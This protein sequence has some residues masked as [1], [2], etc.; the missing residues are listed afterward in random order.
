MNFNDH[1]LVLWQ[2]HPCFV[3]IFFYT[4]ILGKGFNS[5]FLLILSFHSSPI[6][7]LTRQ[8]FTTT[9]LVP[10]STPASILLPYG[11]WLNICLIDLSYVYCCVPSK[12]CKFFN[13]IIAGKKTMS[14]ENPSLKTTN[15]PTC[16]ELKMYY[17]NIQCSKFSRRLLLFYSKYFSLFTHCIQLIS[18]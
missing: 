4:K 9:V 8:F 12:R 15:S 10:P 2:K 7:H 6:P 1:L 17:T 11:P 13:Y 16:K 14:A 5:I 3:S 18:T